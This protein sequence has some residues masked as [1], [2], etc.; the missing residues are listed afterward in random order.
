MQYT[1]PF[2]KICFEAT[3]SGP[4]SVTWCL[5]ELFS[6]P[7][8][9]VDAIGPSDLSLILAFPDMTFVRLAKNDTSEVFGC[10]PTFTCLHV[11]VLSATILLCSPT[12]LSVSQRFDPKE[13]HQWRDVPL[14]I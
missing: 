3:R 6:Y 9:E 8:K 5:A 12:P 2:S 11:V 14:T 13:G 1:S 7:A 10:L 4:M